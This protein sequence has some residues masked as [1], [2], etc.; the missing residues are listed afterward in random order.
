M[1]PRI[2]PRIAR[3]LPIVAIVTLV[4]VSEIDVDALLVVIH[5]TALL[6]DRA[7]DVAVAIDLELR[8][9]AEEHTDAFSRTRIAEAPEAASAALAAFDSSRASASRRGAPSIKRSVII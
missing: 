8:R 7:F 4:S 6:R 3:D 1:Q 9:H 2:D 5:H